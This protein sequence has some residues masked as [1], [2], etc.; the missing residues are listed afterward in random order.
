MVFF[1]NDKLMIEGR[2]SQIF[3]LQITSGLENSSGYAFWLKKLKNDIDIALKASR[4]TRY[5]AVYICEKKKC[6]TLAE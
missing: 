1:K 5:H 3:L 6:G 2:P 4:I